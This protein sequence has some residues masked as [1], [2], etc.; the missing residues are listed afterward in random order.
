MSLQD[1]RRLLNGVL[2]DGEP[3]AYSSE[4]TCRSK[5][6]SESIAGN[7]ILVRPEKQR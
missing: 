7:A 6:F 3:V 4:L 2:I 1:A 5:C